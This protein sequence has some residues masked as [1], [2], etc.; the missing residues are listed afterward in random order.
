VNRGKLVG[1]VG[2]SDEFAPASEDFEPEPMAGHRRSHALELRS[3]LQELQPLAKMN[4]VEVELAI[5]DENEL[6]DGPGI[7]REVLKDTI[8]AAT[9][10]A[11]CG[12]VLI[13]SQTIDERRQ[14]RITDDEACA[15]RTD[16]EIV[17][18]EEDRQLA[19]WGGSVTMQSRPGAGTTVTVCLPRPSDA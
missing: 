14:I 10:A 8:A 19:A 7:P 4:F 2:D 6:E 17:T 13:T 15:N 18:L 5:A 16:R 1:A 3:I 12:N 9:L 11:P